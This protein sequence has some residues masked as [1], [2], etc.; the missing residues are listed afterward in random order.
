MSIGSKEVE[1][2]GK[3]G[4]GASRQPSKAKEI[5][6]VVGFFAVIIAAA[7][8]VGYLIN[9]PG[10]SLCNNQDMVVKGQYEFHSYTAGAG[11]VEYLKFPDG[12][13]MIQKHSSLG[14]KTWGYRDYIDYGDGR[15][16]VVTE[17]ASE[18]KYYKMNHVLTRD[19]D[20][21]SNQK[22]FDEADRLL[23][24][25]NEKYKSE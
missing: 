17:H 20:Y 7:V 23:R 22:E 3:K 18:I 15:V 16:D 11:H 24:E 9:M 19:A 12:K 25:L 1:E 13:V 2:S 14:T 21:T 10:N 4:K 8:V 5:A 6:I